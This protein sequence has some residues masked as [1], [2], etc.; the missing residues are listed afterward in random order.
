MIDRTHDLPISRQAKAL[1]V[2]R[3]RGLL[4]APPGLARRPARHAADRRTA[5]GAPV[6]A[7]HAARFS[8]PGGHCDR[9]PAC[10]NSDEAHGNRGDLS[11][12]EYVEP[13]AR[14]QYLP[15]SATGRDGRAAQP[16]L[17][18]GYHLYPDG[19]RLRL[20]RRRR[21]LVHPARAFASG[22][23]H[24]GGR[25]FRVEALEE[26]IGKHGKPEIFNS[27]QGSQFTSEAFTGILEKN[28][29][30]ISMD[31]KGSSLTYRTSVTRRSNHDLYLSCDNC[32]LE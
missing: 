30:A 22:V 1:N 17:G 21:R 19:A 29:I 16:G 12:T 6:R 9:P 5:S 13:R 31:G 24:D 25:L 18:D 14:P 4:Q 15:V 8:G 11:P 2:S 23:D 3:G 32:L 7:P 27:D 28:G 20:S 10:R 26:A